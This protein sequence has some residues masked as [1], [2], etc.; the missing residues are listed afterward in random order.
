MRGAWYAALRAG[1]C[2]CEYVGRDAVIHK[3]WR[4]ASER[5]SAD[6][7]GGGPCQARTARTK[8]WCKSPRKQVRLLVARRTCHCAV[9]KL[10]DSNGVVNMPMCL[11]ATRRVPVDLRVPVVRWR[12]PWSCAAIRPVGVCRTKLGRWVVRKKHELQGREGGRMLGVM[13]ICASTVR[14]GRWVERVTDNVIRES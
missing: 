9:K 4:Q 2:D 1:T 6:E 10:T 12:P 14:G 13:H 8:C 3:T 5:A 7:G 11:L